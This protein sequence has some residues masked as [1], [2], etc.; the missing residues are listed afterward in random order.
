MFMAK[1]EKVNFC[2]H[3]QSVSAYVLAFIIDIDGVGLILKG[4]RITNN[5]YVDVDDIGENGDA[6]LCTTNN[7]NCC[8]KPMGE[9]Y[10][11]GSNN[12]TVGIKGNPPNNN[13]FYRNRG[14]GPGVVR[15]HRRRSSS[16]SKRGRFRCEVPDADNKMQMFFVNIGKFRY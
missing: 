1:V 11:P 2:R 7:T 15:L 16:K 9:W 6:L 13:E 14:S 10:F 4:T 5:S 12:M 8:N 3:V